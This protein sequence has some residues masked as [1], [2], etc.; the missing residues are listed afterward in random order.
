MNFDYRVIPTINPYIMKTVGECEI[1]LLSKFRLLNLLKSFFQVS[2]DRSSINIKTPISIS[3]VHTVSFSR[4]H[5]FD[6]LVGI[7]YSRLRSK[8]KLDFY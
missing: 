1:L 5:E 3:M 7:A 4:Q 6:R 2:V 8:R